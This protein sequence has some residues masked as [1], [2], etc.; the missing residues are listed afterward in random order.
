[1]LYRFGVAHGAGEWPEGLFSLAQIAAVLL[2]L[3]A[4]YR[5]DWAHKPSD[6]YVALAMDLLILT[7]AFDRG[8]IAR[9]LQTAPRAQ[10]RR[11]VLRDLYGPDLLPPVHPVSGAALVSCV[12]LDDLRHALVDAASGG[13]N[14]LRC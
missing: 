2:L 4:I 9:A 14:P 1:M 11:M 6:I 5:T 13:P 10:A 12:G 7:L 3:D 8:A